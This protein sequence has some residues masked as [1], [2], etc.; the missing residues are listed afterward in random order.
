[1]KGTRTLPAPPRVF[2]ASS[3]VALAIILFV[4]I[5]TIWI[6]HS[7]STRF[8]EAAIFGLA[9]VWA[10]R[11]IV[12]PY[13]I[14]GSWI[15][16]PLTGAALIG[17]VQL[18]TGNTVNRW[19]TWNAFL[20]WAAYLL[21]ALLALQVCSVSDFLVRF[22]RA[23]LYF[24]AALSVVSVLQLFTSEGKIFWLFESGYNDMVLGPFINRDHYAAFIELLL[25]LALFEAFASDEF[26]LAGTG[27]AAAMFASVIAG[28]SRAG[29]I[30][31]V[32]ESGTVLFLMS[33]RRLSSTR[34]VATVFLSFLFFTGAFTAVVGWNQLWERFQDPDPYHSR[35]HML[36]SAMAMTRD[37]PWTGFGLGTFEDV[38]PAYAS[39]D[40]GTIVTHAHNDWAE[41]AADGGLP[42]LACMATAAIGILPFAI[43]S[44]WGLGVIFLLLH[45]LVDFPMQ[46]GAIAL[47]AF[48]LIGV[49]LTCDSVTRC[50]PSRSRSRSSW[51]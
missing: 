48:A 2:V 42:L 20:K 33:Q 13:S 34:K 47:W 16:V 26:T 38:Y 32:V 28:A 39:Y 24:G 17:L 25:P 10:V 44:L 49:V 21:A 36:S 7:W 8:F 22:R 46:G 3:V 23:L 51:P 29:S 14:R 1:M 30:L 15:L 45:S 41:W 43:R 19:E 4:S 27:I 9:A 37:K 40:S 5:L 50:A 12:D 6:S 18:T 31:A 11:M 35:S